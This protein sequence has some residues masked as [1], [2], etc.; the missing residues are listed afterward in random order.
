[1]SWKARAQERRGGI[2]FASVRTAAGAT[3]LGQARKR[4][5]VILNRTM[6]IGGDFKIL[7][8]DSRSILERYEELYPPG[9]YPPKEYFVDPRDIPKLQSQAFAALVKTNASETKVDRY[10][11]KNR[12]VLAAALNFTNFGHHGG[13]VVPQQTVRPSTR[14]VAHGLR[15]DYLVAGENSD[16]VGWFVVELKGVTDTVFTDAKGPIRLSRAANAGICQLVEYLDYCASNQSFLRDELQFKR[17]R[18]PRGILIIGRE[19]ELRD[20]RRQKLRAALNEAL[21]PRVEIRSYDALFRMFHLG[22]PIRRNSRKRT[23]A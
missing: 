16:G 3:A 10:L 4:R 12:A 2:L 15:P 23:G 19:Q 11:R 7:R 1:M 17:F 22:T 20:R 18:E 14:P 13:W 6:S 21:R 9:D 8:A 5:G